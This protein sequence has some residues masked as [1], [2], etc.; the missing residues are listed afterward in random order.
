[1]TLCIVDAVIGEVPSGDYQIE[2]LR[3]NRQPSFPPNVI[4]ED[5]SI[6]SHIKCAI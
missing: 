2:I 3:A 4:A 5:S 6:A 1:M